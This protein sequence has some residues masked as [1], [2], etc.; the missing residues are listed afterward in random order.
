EI[1][2]ILEEQKANN[3]VFPKIENQE[4]IDNI[5][6]NLEVSDGIM[7]A[8]GDMGVEIPP[9]KVTKDQKDLIRQ[10]NKLVK[11]VIKATQ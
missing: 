5:A 10:C 11:T 6:Q 8:R 4:G 9:E 7:V 1:R 2:E 3:S